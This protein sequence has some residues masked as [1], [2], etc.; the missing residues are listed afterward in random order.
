M[1][2]TTRR[3]EAVHG[4]ALDIFNIKETDQY[5][6]G[7]E[8][9]FYIDI[10]KYEFTDTIEKIK[11]KIQTFTN[12]DI[13][14]DMVSLPIDEDKNYCI[15]IKPDQSLQSHGVEISIPITSQVGVKHYITHILP[16]IEEFGYTNEDTGLH[17]HISTTKQDG[18]NFPFYVY[19]L[20]C[21]DKNLLSAWKPRLGYSENVMDV[22]LKKSKSDARIVKTKKGTIWNLEKLEANHIE[23]KSIGGIDYHV[24]M[25]KILDEFD[26][27]VECF[28]TVY[29]DSNS[30]YRERLIKEH[31]ALIA[32]T[33]EATKTKFIVAVTDMGLI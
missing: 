28:D 5:R 22:L 8:F 27:Y 2:Q 1:A 14:V 25:N 15:Q 30:E 11:N 33:D 32:S 19:M 21:H 13:L 9:E 31:K 20:M 6:F 29:M 17:F 12:A 7:C 4:N 18:V 26:M 24:Q 10:E 16:L 23:I 3:Y